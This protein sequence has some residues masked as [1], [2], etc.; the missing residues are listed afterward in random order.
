[1]LPAAQRG[2]LAIAL[3]QLGAIRERFP[4]AQVSLMCRCPQDDAHWFLEADQVC[5]ELFPLNDE[6]FSR[7]LLRFFRILTGRTGDA[8]SDEYRAILESADVLVFCGGGSAGGYGFGNL[9]LNAW[10]PTMLA[11]RSGIPVLFIGLGIVR[12]RSALHRW[13]LT[14]VLNDA[15]GVAARDPLSFEAL[16]EHLPGARV[17]Q[18]ADWA[19]LLPAA[20]RETADA[21]FARAGCPE[22][23]RLRLGLNL[24]SDR[25]VG[26]DGEIAAAA[27]TW[28]ETLLNCL[29]AL[30]KKLEAEVFVFSMN[31]PP[32]SDD[33]EYARALLSGIDPDY[34]CRIHMLKGDYTPSEIKAMIATMNL[35]IGTRLHPSLFAASAGVPTVTVHDQDKVRGFMQQIGMK[36]WHLPATGLESGVFLQKVLDLNARGEDISAQ[37]QRQ[38]PEMEKAARSNLDW[39]PAVL[40]DHG[41]GRLP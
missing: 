37:L 18:T 20:E 36:D 19:W 32:A 27:G 39:I 41:R 38:I 26:P 35:F 5:S 22:N 13:L 30:I 25:A 29:P 4:G 2:D 10:C 16:Q 7:R 1:M 33:R 14:R 11:R 12:P 6:S 31:G 23:G 8:I 24:R 9:L 17:G 15:D 3:A 34:K 28:G 40:P 21:L